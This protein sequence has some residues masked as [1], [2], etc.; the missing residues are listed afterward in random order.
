MAS[1]DLIIWVDH[2]RFALAKLMPGQASRPNAYF[3]GQAAAV[4]PP[5]LCFTSQL[6]G[7]AQRGSVWQPG[8]ATSLSVPHL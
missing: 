8:L 7:G 5:P 1:P 4:P 6:T 3:A 2:V